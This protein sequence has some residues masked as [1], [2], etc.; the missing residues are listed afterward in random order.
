M[1]LNSMRKIRVL[2]WGAAA[3]L[4]SGC[5]TTRDGLVYRAYHNMHAK[6]NGFFYANEAME[7]ADQVLYEGYKENWD[8]ILPVFP[9]VDESTAQQVYPLMERAIEKCTNV[10]D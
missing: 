3:L 5:S 1:G 2:G 7:E 6:Y 4:L 8:E 9:P 10:V